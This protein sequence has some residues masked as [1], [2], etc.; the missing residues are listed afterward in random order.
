MGKL[1]QC[2]HVLVWINYQPQVYLFGIP[3]RNRWNFQIKIIPG[4]FIYQGTNYKV[5]VGGEEPQEIVQE[6]E[7]S[8]IK[9]V[10]TLSL[11]RCKVEGIMSRIQHGRIMTIRLH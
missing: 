10:I 1:F 6:P 8:S 11:K 4:V 5:W 3:S 2:K 7:A 9:T